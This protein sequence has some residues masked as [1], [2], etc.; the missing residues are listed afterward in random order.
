MR[1][2]IA[3]FASLVAFPAAASGGISCGADHGPILIDIQSGV[4]HGMGGP[5]FAFAGELAIADQR[6]SPAAR[7]ARFEQEHVAQYWLDGETLRLVLYREAE[8]DVPYFSVQVVVRTMVDE[9]GEDYLGDFSVA[10]YQAGD[11]QGGEAQL[12]E[13][14]GPISCFVE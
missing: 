10:A 4:T 12:F 11:S 7:E 13:F 14:T 8:G 5:L 6:L 9:S 2:I 3:A 1:L